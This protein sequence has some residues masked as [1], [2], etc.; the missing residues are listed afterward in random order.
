M[1]TSEQQKLLGF[2][3]TTIHRLRIATTLPL[4]LQ[5]QDFCTPNHAPMTHFVLTK[6]HHIVKTKGF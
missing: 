4:M 3:L 6:Q 1:E 5:T 2:M